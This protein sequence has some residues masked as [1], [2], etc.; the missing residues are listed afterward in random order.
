MLDHHARH[1]HLYL[2]TLQESYSGNRINL[3]ESCI[4]LHHFQDIHRGVTSQL[5]TP[6]TVKY[7]RTNA[8]PC[9]PSKPRSSPWPEAGSPLHELLSMYF[10]ICAMSPATVQHSDPGQRSSRFHLFIQVKHSNN[11]LS[12]AQGK[13]KKI[14]LQTYTCCFLLFTSSIE[15]QTGRVWESPTKAKRTRTNKAVTARSMLR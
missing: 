2:N 12:H 10:K 4:S 5:I 15:G 6:I 11:L 13:K 7:A 3:H 14:F 8:L 1:S 9:T